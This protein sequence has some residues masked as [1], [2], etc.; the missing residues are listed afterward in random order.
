[1]VFGNYIL[2]N[3]EIDIEAIFLGKS[4]EELLD[5]FLLEEDQEARKH[6]LGLAKGLLNVIQSKGRLQGVRLLN[7]ILS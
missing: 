1:M 5:L 3:A 2:E 4:D 7:L 6:A